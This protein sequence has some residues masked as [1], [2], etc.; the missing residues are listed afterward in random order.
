[1]PLRIV[2]FNLSHDSSA[3][4]V[5]N[6][7]LVTALALERITGVKRGVVP[8]HAYA[9]AMAALTRDL[10][11]GVGLAPADIDYWIATST[12]SRDQ[13]DEDRLTDTLGLLAAPE[14]RLVLP[15]P[16]HH[17]AHASAAFY[18]SGLPEAA[19][20]V[21]D[22]YGAR[23]GEQRERESAFVFTS[24]RAPA[25]LWRTL[26]NE[27]RIAGRARKGALWI[28]R[29]LS[30]VGEV[31]RVVTLALGFAEPGST[32][33]DAGKTMGLASYG[34]RLSRQSLFI[35][36]DGSDLSFDGA[37][38]ALVELGLA[39]PRH[40]G[41]QL[42]P[43]P[44]GAPLEQFHRDLAAQ[45][46]AEFE[47]ACLHLV[48]RTMAASGSRHLVLSGGCFLNSMLNAR[49]ARECGLDR[50]YIFPAATD[51]GN[52]AGAA[53]YAHHVLL[54]DQN[55][56]HAG[57]RELRHAFLGPARLS[58]TPAQEI[59]ERASAL[60]LTAVGHSS[61]RTAARAA[62][63]AIAR[64]E[65]IGWFQDRAEFGPRSLGA[66]SIL[67]HPGRKG[68]K[69]R[70]NA[71]VKFREA[72]R[73][74]AASVLA[75]HAEKWFDLP[76][77][78]SPFMLLVCPVRPEQADAVPEVVH[79]DGTCRLQTVDSHLPGPFRALIEAFEEQ[80]G[81]PMVLNT[82]FNVRGKPIVEDWRE[83]LDCLF[84]SRLDRLFIGRHEIPAPDL[85]ALCPL[86]ESP[87]GPDLLTA[88][89]RTL[90]QHCSGTS[91]LRNIAASIGCDE[92]TALDRA[93]L[94]RRRRL[95][96]WAHVDT[97]RPLALPLPQYDPHAAG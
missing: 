5:E 32:Y 3:C 50:L 73:P 96:R 35:H 62:A 77:G 40:E 68:M 47:T 28:P 87:D 52:A 1:M 86:H 92:E 74:F 25:M 6:G 57:T 30:G 83:A 61:P 60:G 10:L 13:Y 34:H 94:L 29:E 38:D 63:E 31:Y 95:L 48:G 18:T 56:P 84:G 58:S 14:R 97:P 65:I 41:L 37:A 9:A 4:L 64:G 42:R 70:L 46:Q 33:D 43:R 49:I 79:T 78:D 21:I 67:C 88:E 23:I 16:G 15:H 36:T 26:R 53:L 81:L 93:L 69:D 72:F 17:L 55:R 2:G 7:H 54:A 71:R 75:E 22:A 8:M 12:E 20:L 90:L 85:A 91:T 39:V 24:G 66:R 76:T 59:T 51:D 11:A 82:S 80:T 27:D 19:A 89:D 44:A 45:I